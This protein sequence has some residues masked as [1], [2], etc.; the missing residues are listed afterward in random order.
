MCRRINGRNIG[1]CQEILFRQV[2]LEL[3]RQL[4]YFHCSPSVVKTFSF[5]RLIDDLVEG[6]GWHSASELYTQH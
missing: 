6:L 5:R 3:I 4:A 2:A 1:F